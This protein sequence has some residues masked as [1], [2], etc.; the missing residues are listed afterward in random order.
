MRALMRA[1][2]TPTP[3]TFS[4]LRRPAND[5]ETRMDDVAGVVEM[6]GDVPIDASMNEKAAERASVV[7][8]QLLDPAERLREVEPLRRVIVE[9]G[10]LATA[11]G[12]GADADA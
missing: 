10:V 6:L 1:E 5:V 9:L 4:R 11:T 3:E 2:A 12:G 7:G 8:W